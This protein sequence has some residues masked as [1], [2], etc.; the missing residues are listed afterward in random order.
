MRRI[1]VVCMGNIC[2]SPV[3]ERLLLKTLHGRA[4]VSSAGIGALAGYPADAVAADVAASHGVSLDGH[5]ARQFT[6]EMGLRQDLI[7]VMETAF[8]QAVA[9]M[10]PALFGRTMLYDQ[11]TGA[12][13][14]PDP[15]GQSRGFHE[16][17]F[18]QIDRATTG[19]LSRL[20][21]NW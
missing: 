6:A 12:V 14:I 19:W 20:C 4:E 21:A 10:E 13:D 17:V 2:R 15:F 16:E 8:R 18:T 1:L 3:G 5:V 11:W 9:A 7:L